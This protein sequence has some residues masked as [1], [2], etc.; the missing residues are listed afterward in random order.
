MQ[1][2]VN[3][4]WNKTKNEKK[5]NIGVVNCNFIQFFNEKCLWV[6]RA[7]QLQLKQNSSTCKINETHVDKI[8]KLGH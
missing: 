6:L 1:R 7:D 2:E 3:S 8:N 5:P 4:L